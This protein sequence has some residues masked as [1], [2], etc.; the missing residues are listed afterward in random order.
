ML[1]S[2][3]LFAKVEFGLQV[4]GGLSMSRYKN[5]SLKNAKLSSLGGQF[6]NK[7]GGGGGVAAR[8]WFNKFVGLSLGV[9][10]NQGGN[11]RKMTNKIGGTQVYTQDERINYIVIPL[12][13]HV[14]W[15]NEVVKIFG[16]AG[17]YYGYAINGKYHNTNVQNGIVLSDESGD[18]DFE[19]TYTRTDAGVRFGAG[20]EVY[21]SKN[22]KHG[23]TA[24]FTFDWGLS[25]ILQEDIVYKNHTYRFTNSRTLIQ[26]GYLIRFGQIAS[27][28]KKLPEL[29]EL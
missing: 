21:V 28:D 23:L 17:G 5:Y 6:N 10:V 11:I 22:R 26:I 16:T 15:G 27:S 12:C 18:L 2:S 13:A 29:P 20:I 19:N 8:L 14:G 7:I 9:E 25:K 24:D 4:H 1:M 3:T